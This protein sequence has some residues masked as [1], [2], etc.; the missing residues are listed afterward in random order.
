MS[1]CVPFLKCSCAFREYLLLPVELSVQSLSPVYCL[2]FC[3]IA[4]LLPEIMFF[5]VILPFFEGNGGKIMKTSNDHIK[6][7]KLLLP[8]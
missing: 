3:S 7:N 8:Y 6:H 4:H 5:P 2:D 1:S